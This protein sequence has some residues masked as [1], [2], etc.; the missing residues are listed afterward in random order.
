MLDIN[1]CY[2]GDCLEIMDHVDDNS[3]DM[4]LTD[5]PYGTTKCS[6]DIILPFDKLWKQYKRITKENAA[7][8]LFGQEPF[9]SYLRLSNIEDYRYDIYWEKERLTNVNQTKRRV[10]KTVETISVFYHKQCTYNPI[11]QRHIGRA[12]SNVPK[13][14]NGKLV[15]CS[16]K[17]VIPYNDTGYR[18]PTQVW[19]YN[20]DNLRSLIH[21]TQKPLKLCEDLIR[22][23]S[24][25][26][27]LIL[28]SCAGSMTTGVAAINTDRNFICIE[29]DDI[30]Y[31]KGVER[32]NKAKDIP[33]NRS[34]FNI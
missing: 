23:F 11:M 30:A 25:E 28:D 26:G 33:K 34:L 32:V 18:Y 4:I 8:I 19:S 9:S 17:S 24:N 29:L 13:G 15:D 1:N 2:L 20:R 21:E 5:L 6:W 27:D 14:K 16:E 12:V 22:T 31:N 7:I 3:V 10:G